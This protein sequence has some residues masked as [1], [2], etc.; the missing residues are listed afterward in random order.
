[1]KPPI[2]RGKGSVMTFLAK[3]DN[4]GEYNGWS[5]KHKFYYLTNAVEDPAAQVLWDLQSGGAVSYKKFRAILVQVY[6]G[7]VQA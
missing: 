1:M 7:P 6:G 3:F 4:Y 5:E 2:F